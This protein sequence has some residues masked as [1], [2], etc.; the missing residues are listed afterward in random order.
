MLWATV[1]R[2]IAETLLALIA[3]LHIDLARNWRG[4]FELIARLLFYLPVPIWFAFRVLA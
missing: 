4:K 1:L 3:A 2:L